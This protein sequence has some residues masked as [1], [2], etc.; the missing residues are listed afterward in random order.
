MLQK[1]QKLLKKLLKLKVLQSKIY[2]S[3]SMVSKTPLRNQRGFLCLWS[4]FL[5]L[6]WF[7]ALPLSGV[8]P[9]GA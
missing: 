1:L 8:I 3:A 9:G 4:G 2:S 5:L 6:A 7:W